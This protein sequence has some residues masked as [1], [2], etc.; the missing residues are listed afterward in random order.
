MTETRGKSADSLR[1][2][3]VAGSRPKSRKATAA[4]ILSILGALFGFLLLPMLGSL[5]AVF[6]GLSA[7]RDIRQHPAL[8][9]KTKATVAVI[10]G[11]LG[12]PASFMIL[13]SA[14]STGPVS[15]G[16]G[17]FL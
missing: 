17:A 12:P 11:I 9:G 14:L 3:A 15:G 10:L 2:N 7:R 5:A 1:T 4:L 16:G 8:K 13:V 6:L